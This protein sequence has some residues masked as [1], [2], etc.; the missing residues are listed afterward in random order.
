VQCVRWMS[1]QRRRWTAWRPL[2]GVVCVGTCVGREAGGDR[3][4]YTCV[5]SLLREEATNGQREQVSGRV[6]R[7][8][9]GGLV[10]V[11]SGAGCWRRFNNWRA[12]RPGFEVWNGPTEEAGKMRCPDCSA[13]STAQAV[14][15]YVVPACVC[16]GRP[17][18]QAG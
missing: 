13:A 2:S 18:R 7:T 15:M 5:Y 6:K 8:R 4:V 9:E 10:G 16:G 1:M 17:W 14:V 3:C 12:R 11:W